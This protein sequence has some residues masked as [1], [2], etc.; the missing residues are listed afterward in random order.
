MARQAIERMV[1]HSGLII[2]MGS[3]P[4]MKTGVNEQDQDTYNCSNNY[5]FNIYPFHTKIYFLYYCNSSI[6][7]ETT[8]YSFYNFVN[9]CQKVS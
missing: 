8:K 9:I 1:L 7:F 2:Y 6:L 5:N 3:C 4:A